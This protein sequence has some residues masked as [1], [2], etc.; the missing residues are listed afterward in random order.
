MKQRTDVKEAKKLT[1]LTTTLFTERAT[2][3]ATAVPQKNRFPSEQ[4]DQKLTLTRSVA[5]NRKKL[6]N[7]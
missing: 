4:P 3:A 7:N 5:C 1:S 6:R 2:K